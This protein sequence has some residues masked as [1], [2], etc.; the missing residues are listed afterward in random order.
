[1]DTQERFDEMEKAIEKIK[2][3]IGKLNVSSDDLNAKK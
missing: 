3:V 2:E 1:M